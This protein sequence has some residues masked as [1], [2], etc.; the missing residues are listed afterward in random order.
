V[1]SVADSSNQALLLLGRKRA[2]RPRTPQHP[3]GYGRERFFY[4]FIVAVVLFTV[5]A[6]FSL[7]EGWHK[8]SDPHAVESPIWA[9]GVL[10]F[11]ILLETFSFWTA[12]HESN[13][14]RGQ[15]GWVAFIRRAKAPELPVV[16][17]EDLA[18]L[19]GLFLALGGV[20]MAVIT[21]DGRWDGIGSMAIGVLLGLVA[22]VLAIETKSLLIGESAH[23]HVERE[24]VAA[25]EAGTEVERVIHLRTEHIGPE[26]LLVAAK[27]AVRHDDTA[28]QVAQGI[29]AA[30]QRVRAAVPIARLIYLEPDL[31]D[32][33][34]KS[35]NV[36]PG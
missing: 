28:Q 12:I 36:T 7:Y 22:I 34:K 4:A 10:T 26:E 23:E 18:A 14:V 24:I 3:F 32:V 21:D 8:V 6:V 29:D 25:L 13:R 33:A 30:E 16:L 27:I 5:G 2:E 31:Y 1:H 19:L 20:G 17:L 11:A 15:Q 35:S 9:F